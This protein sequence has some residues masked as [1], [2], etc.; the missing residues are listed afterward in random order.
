MERIKDNSSV[1]C[2]ESNT[3]VWSHPSDEE[4][5]KNSPLREL[6]GPLSVEERRTCETPPGIQEATCALWRQR[7]RRRGIQGSIHRARCFSVS[8]GS[9]KILGHFS[10]SFLVWLEKQVTQFQRQNDR[11]SQ[12]VTNAERR[13]SWNVDQISSTTNTNR[14]DNI[15]DPSGTS[16]KKLMW[17]P[18][19]TALFG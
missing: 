15:E 9:G 11:S 3:K 12:I 2:Q 18:H 19:W 4:G 10:Q 7:Q 14:W 17:S 5:W 6:D 8:D 13:M 1:G 16:W